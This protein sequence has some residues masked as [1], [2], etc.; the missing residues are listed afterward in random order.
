MAASNPPSPPALVVGA[1]HRSAS[2]GLRD[3][4]FVEDAQ[5]PAFLAGLGEAGVKPAMILSTCDRIEV[6]ALHE[7]PDAAAERAL[8]IMAAHGGVPMA[9]LK[10]QTYVLSG[11]DAVRHIFS[12]AASL[13]SLVVGEPQ[14]LGQVKACHRMARD[15]GMTGNGFEALLQAAYGAAKR[16]R[17]ETAIGERPVSIA[18]AAS[19]LAQDLHGDLGRAAGLL[20]GAGEMGELVAEA[21][22]RDGLG[23][24]TVIHPSVSRAETLARALDCH[25]AEFDELPRLLDDADIVLTALGSRRQVLNS[26][27]MLV[28]LH[29]RRKK[30]V[31]IIDTSIPGDVEPA[32]N[33]IDE[34]FLYDLGDL[35]RVALEGQSSRV[36]EAEGAARIVDQEVEAFLR[37]RAER[38]AVP[39]LN[40]LRG[41]FEKVRSEVLAEAGDDAGKATR[42]L[43]NRLLHG[44]SEAMREAAAEDSGW[45]AAEE[46]IRRLFGLAGGDGENEENEENK[47]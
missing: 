35:E 39:A 25:V 13:D 38:S 43:I 12:V 4:L 47:E 11:E 1:N 27:M 36:A 5:V 2:L 28:A 33:R 45:R 6:Q 46:V 23:L 31:F 19:Q 34:A 10:D 40:E 22:I 41:H 30:P 26:D 15:A 3:R 16:V 17:G 18:A 42:L 8:E 7:D 37:G 29:R 24:L 20:I 44:P 9:E 32:V 21:L 14:V